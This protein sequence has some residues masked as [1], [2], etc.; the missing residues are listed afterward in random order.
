LV[1][2]VQVDRR[3]VRY[4]GE[5]V[6]AVAMAEIV[7]WFAMGVQSFLAVGSRGSRGARRGEEGGEGGACLGDADLQ[8]PWPPRGSVGPGGR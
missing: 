1:E 7:A 5:V 8:N 4:A 2:L 3:K 6:V